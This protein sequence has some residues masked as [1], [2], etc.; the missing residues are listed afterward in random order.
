MGRGGLGPSEGGHRQCPG[1]LFFAL[2]VSILDIIAT[3]TKCPILAKIRDP[4]VCRIYTSRH[5]YGESFPQDPVPSLTVV[6][7]LPPLV[8]V[9]VQLGQPLRMAFV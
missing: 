6:Q 1:T 9:P 7:L 2:G 5:I 8:I 3:R 4:F